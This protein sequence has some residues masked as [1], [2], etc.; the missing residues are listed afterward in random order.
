MARTDETKNMIAEVVELGRRNKDL[1]PSVR[2]WCIHLN[3][4]DISAGMV[5]EIYNLPIRFRLSCKHAS[6]AQEGMPLDSLAEAFILEACKNCVHHSPGNSLNF[7]EAILK[8]RE[9]E[10]LAIQL[11]KETEDAAKAALKETINT[12]V[13]KTKPTANQPALSILRLIEQLDGSEAEKSA[14][15]LL[16]ASIIKPEFFLPEALDAVAIYFDN[17]T[18][19]GKLIAVVT[20]IVKSGKKLTKLCHERCTEL[21]QKSKHLEDLAEIGIEIVDFNGGSEWEEWITTF[22]SSLN[23]LHMYG[24]A[25]PTPTEKREAFIQACITRKEQRTREIIGS[26]LKSENKLVRVNMAR[27]IDFIGAKAPGFSLSL[28]PSLVQAFE[29]SDSRDLESADHAL[30]DTIAS[31]IVSTGDHALKKFEELFGSLKSEAAKLSAWEVYDLLLKNEEF[32][33]DH[34]DL[35][36]SMAEEIPELLIDRNLKKEWRDKAFDTMEL[37]VKSGKAPDQTFSTLIGCLS[38]INDEKQAHRHYLEELKSNRVSSFNPLAGLDHWDIDLHE[39]SLNSFRSNLVDMAAILLDKKP[40]STYPI[41]SDVL[42]NLGETYVP[43]FKTDLLA[44]A[45]K[46]LNSPRYIAQYLPFLYSTLFDR[47]VNNR[48]QAIHFLRNLIDEFPQ[49]V[50]E[51]LLAIVDVFPDD[52]EISVRANNLLLVNSIALSPKFL[53]T[54]SHIGYVEKAFRQ[55]Y[56]YILKRAVTAARNVFPKMSV[57]QVTV[58]SLDL[59]NLALM[60]DPKNEDLAEQALSVLIELSL[61]NSQFLDAVVV[62]IISPLCKS[63]DV[64]K[65]RKYVEELERIKTLYPKYSIIW[66]KD[67]LGHLSKTWPDRYNNSFDPRNA[68][69][70]SIFNCSHR[71]LN[72]CKAEIVA[73]GEV[74]AGRDPIDALNF[75]YLFCRFHFYNE[76]ID[77]IGLIESKVADTKSNDFLLT[78]I[79]LIKR[80]VDSFTES[81]SVTA[82]QKKIQQSKNELQIL[83]SKLN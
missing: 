45:M 38:R 7:G 57:D 73:A 79:R 17:L 25:D 42:A 29:L 40:E 53:L 81:S 55:N 65:S 11:R 43:A 8:A 69:Y 47:D 32:L 18:W 41:F 30:S 21:L 63:D 68:I 24:Y 61:A 16:E 78:T 36:G 10:S 9:N 33:E 28:L 3:V 71:L 5:A 62:R 74:I 34:T 48:V 37:V 35:A 67:A 44:V 83:R 15:E 60:N 27:L 54:D 70:K 14:N 56:I 46:G 49:L 75:I 58:L 26:F 22:L 82:I 13:A 20:N 51:T 72:R 1:L 59:A 80:L 12:L 31:I 64:Q 66:L 39:S 19:G 4:L 6:L 77:L 50:T 2:N 52:P 76:A 23:Y